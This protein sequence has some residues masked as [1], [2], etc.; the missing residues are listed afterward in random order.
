M[1]L[2]VDRG[3][4]GAAT[5]DTLVVV[6]SFVRGVGFEAG[7]RYLVYA[8]RED[9]ALRTHTRTRSENDGCCDSP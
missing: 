2:R 3:W 8:A 1:T 7:G 9:G 4:K 5:G 6:D